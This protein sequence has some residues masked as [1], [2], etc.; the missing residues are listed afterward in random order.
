MPAKTTTE[1]SEM[2]FEAKKTSAT[3]ASKTPRNELPFTYTPVYDGGNGIQTSPAMEMGN[4]LEIY[5]MR[6]SRST[7]SL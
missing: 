5:G 2:M 1:N 6:S 3:V 4:S 7:M